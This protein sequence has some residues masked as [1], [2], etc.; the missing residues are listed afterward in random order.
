MIMFFYYDN[1]KLQFDNI[2]YQINIYDNVSINNNDIINKI[3]NDKLNLSKYSNQ[4]KIYKKIKKKNNIIY[5]LQLEID[6]SID[7]SDNT[8]YF[9]DLNIIA[10]NKNQEYKFYYNIYKNKNIKLIN[11]N[12]INLKKHGIIN[13]QR[14]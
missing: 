6:R 7:T 13:I 4:I 9:S 14:Y 2:V 8:H 10:Y 12:K 5:I 1:N 3:L 11:N